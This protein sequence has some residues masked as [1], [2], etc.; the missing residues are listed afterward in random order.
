MAPAITLSLFIDDVDAFAISLR[1]HCHITR[2]R[3]YT[4]LLRHA[5]LL[6]RARCQREMPRYD[7]RENKERCHEYA[8]A[9][10]TVR[11]MMKISM[12]PYYFA[13]AAVFHA[14]IAVFFI[15]MMMRR[16]AFIFTLRL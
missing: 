4:I 7:T 14:D 9:C 13:Y 3:F 15:T 1:S 5:D 16:H 8:S 11:A 6:A 10:A 12:L 2:W